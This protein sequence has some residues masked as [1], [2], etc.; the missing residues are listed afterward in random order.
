MKN[1]TW[2]DFT[3]SYEAKRVTLQRKNPPALKYFTPIRF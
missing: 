1:L 3:C 2:V